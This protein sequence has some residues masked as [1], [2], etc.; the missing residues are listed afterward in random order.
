[1]AYP[2]GYKSR[3]GFTKIAVSFPNETFTDI[4]TM[5]VKENKEFSAMVTD[6]VKCGKLCLDESDALEPA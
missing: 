5:A 3:T 1:M 4:L 6:L 2:K